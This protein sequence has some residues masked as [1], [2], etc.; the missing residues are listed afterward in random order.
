[1][2][3]LPTG[4][5]TFLFTDIEGSTRLLQELGG[6]AYGTMQDQHSAIMRAAITAGGGV[7]IRTEG[8]SFFAVFSSATGALHAAVTAQRELAAFPWSDDRPMRVRMGLHTGDGILGGDDYLGIDVNRAARIAATGH[9]GQVVISETTRA[10]V[11]NGLPGGVAIRD[12]GAHRLKDIEHTEHLHD[13]IVDGLDSDYPALRSLQNRR[14]NI[15]APRTSFVGRDRELVEVGQLLDATRLLT[16]TGPGGTGKTRVALKLASDRL[17]RY[18][19]GAFFV[20]LSSVTE[21]AFVI[22]EIARALRVREVPGRDLADLLQDDLRERELLVVLDNLEQLIEA[23]PIVGSLL[24]SSPGLTLLVTSRIP[25]RLSGEQEFQLSPLAL[26]APDQVA[27]AERLTTCESV[28]MFVERAAAVRPG[29][30]ITGEN[31]PAV[32]RIVARL[33]GLPLALELAATRLR[34]VTVEAMAARLEQRLALLT[35]GARDLPERQR[36]LEGTIAWSHELLDPDERRLFARLSVFAG[37]WTLEAAEA[38]CGDGLDVLGSLGALV[39][40]SLVRRTDLEGGELRFSMLETIREFATDR[41]EASDGEDLEALRRRHAEFFRDLA[42][43]AEPFLTRDD[44]VRWLATLERENDNLRTALDWAGQARNDDDVITGLRTATA[45]WRFW[46]E[47]GRSSEGQPRLERLLGLPAAQGRDAVRARALG[48]VGSLAYWQT[49][50]ERVTGPYDE[51]VSIAREIGD[52]R[53]LSWAL[54]DA[55]FVSLVV[56]ERRDQGEAMLRES[57]EAAE[58]GDLYLKAQ[59]STAFAYSRVFSGD[60]AGANEQFERALALHREAGDS[61]YIIEDLLGMAAVASTTGDLDTARVRLQAATT[62]VVES[63]NPVSVGGLLHPHAWLANHDGQ[64]RHA[65]RLMGA[66]QRIEEDFDLHIPK[67]GLAFFGDLLLEAQVVLGE[68]E[69][70]RARAEGFAMNLDQILEL[71]AS[72]GA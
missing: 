10:L 4:T 47:R 25:L 26:P 29:F 2:P 27:D 34:V 48:A 66:Y 51:A 58:E 64:P 35:G 15:P 71:V 3:E 53:L 33:D 52:A 14:T 11:V 50:Y 56:T 42:E 68:Q 54:Y 45:I 18:A 70:E 28:R 24:D 62:V 13:L 17:E 65:A 5:V 20:D 31:A 6:V 36:T 9:G 69:T 60:V 8:D 63:A 57:L 38:V 23:S 21:P 30:R 37:G 22:P 46:K 41:L 67:V 1:M 7:E 59:I 55:S 16:L 12:L 43:E 49:D 40:D 44:Q 61:L 72:H 19:D 32:A 39:D